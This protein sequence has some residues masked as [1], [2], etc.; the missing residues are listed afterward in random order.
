VGIIVHCETVG[1]EEIVVEGGG[2]GGTGAE[3]AD[4]RSAAFG[5]DVGVRF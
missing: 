1:E 3:V 2:E 4:V 5:H